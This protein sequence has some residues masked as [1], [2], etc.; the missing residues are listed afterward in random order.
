MPMIKI[1]CYNAIEDIYKFWRDYQRFGFMRSENIDGFGV[2]QL[3][4]M[5]SNMNDLILRT[6]RLFEEK[7]MDRSNNVYRQVQ[8]GTNSCFSI[9]QR[10]NALPGEYAILQQHSY[11]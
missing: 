11:Y 6:Y 5:D 1:C 10:R 9:H 8:A 3:V 2:N 4:A 7:V